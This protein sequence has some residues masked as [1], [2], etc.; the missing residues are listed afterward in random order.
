MTL[1]EKIIHEALRLFSTHGY[2]N[3]S[4]SDVMA[5]AQTSKGG[6]YN[7]FK[8]KDQLFYAAVDE[9]RGIWREANLDGLDGLDSQVDRVV[10]LFENYQHRYLTCHDLPGGCIFINLAVEL[11]DQRADLA[12]E[13]NKG[14]DQLKGFIT[15]CL[16]T[17]YR[18]GEIRSAVDIEAATEILV[19]G[20]LGACV[21]YTADK[22]GADLNRS[23]TAL[24]DYL[25]S[26]RR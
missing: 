16:D 21:V 19:S 22:S 10:R 14:F 11:N 12:A 4:I 18:K 6:L 26:L 2:M 3:T 1:K 7:H 24:I 9:A 13:V 25:N 5:A 8:S 20:L 15:R 17:A 23:M